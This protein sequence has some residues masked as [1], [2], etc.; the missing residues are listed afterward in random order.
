MNRTLIIDT[1]KKIGEQV[2]LKGWVHIRRDHGKLIFID[3]R[4]RAAALQVVVDPKKIPDSTSIGLQDCVW[5]QGVVRERP[6]GQKNTK[7]VTGEVELAVDALKILNKSRVPPFVVENDV[8]AN[9]E[10]RLR[11][12]YLDLRREPLRKAIIFRHEIVS[13][14]REFLNSKEFIEIETPILTRS[15]PEGARDY[16]VPSRLYPHKFY[17][18]AQS[19]Q[20]YKQLLMVAGFERYYQVARCLRDEN[21]RHDRQPEHTQIDIEMSFVSEDDIFA[22]TEGM[23]V[24][25]MKKVLG[26]DLKTPFPRLAYT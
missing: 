9:D 6:D 5:A 26:Q 18:L 8:K 20:M 1:P 15:M 17:A 22:L 7:M 4:D 10:L 25:I 3:L 2:L 16:L 19:P 24:H 21:P 12:R 11:Y 14:M 23:F 13:A